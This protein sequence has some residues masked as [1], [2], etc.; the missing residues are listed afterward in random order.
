MK[1]RFKSVDGAVRRIRQLEKAI[2]E[3]DALLERWSHERTILAKLS[4]KTPQF[5]NPLEVV[6]AEQLRD[7]ILRHG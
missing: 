4:A 2:K 5:Y 7:E 3:R 1:H 6:Y